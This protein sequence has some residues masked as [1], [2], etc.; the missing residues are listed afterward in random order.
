VACTV[1]VF[2]PAAVGVP[3]NVPAEVSVRPLGN[4]PALF[5]NV[6]GLAPPL[7]VIVWLYTVPVV[8][9]GNV[10]GESAIVGHTTTNV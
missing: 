8:P 3:D 9:L 5:V 6:Y 4:A 7:A 1:N 10:L 2:V